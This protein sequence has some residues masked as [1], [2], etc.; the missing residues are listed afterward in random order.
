M[1]RAEVAAVLP[2]LLNRLNPRGARGGSGQVTA[3]PSPR[4]WIEAIETALGP[5]TRDGLR[6]WSQRNVP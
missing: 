6:R 5:G 3:Q 2:G 1:T 4:A